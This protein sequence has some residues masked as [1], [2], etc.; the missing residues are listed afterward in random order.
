[1]SY[2]DICS[3]VALPLRPCRA[4]DCF[5]RLWDLR[6]GQ[7][8]RHLHCFGAAPRYPSTSVPR[9]WRPLLPKTTIVYIGPRLSSRSLSSARIAKHDAAPSQA[10]I[11]FVSPA[12]SEKP[13]SAVTRGGASKSAK[14]Q[15]KNPEHWISLLEKFLPGDL[16][17]SFQQESRTIFD[18]RTDF[19]DVLKIVHDAKSSAGVDILAY[20]ALTKHRY[21]AVIHLADT[22][23]KPVQMLAEESTDEQLPSNIVWPRYTLS[24]LVR[25]PVELD[26][27][28][29]VKRP[30]AAILV[31]SSNNQDI[32][33][34][35]E[36]VMPL[37]WP[38]LAE[39]VITSVQRPAAEAKQIMYTVHQ[40]IARIHHV[41]LIPASVY[42]HSVPQA[43]TTIQYPPILSL[44]RS[45]ILSTLSDAVWQAHQD[46]AIARANSEGLSRQDPVASE[47]LPGG[48]FRRKLRELGP[49]VWIEFILW[50]CVEGGYPSAGAR[51][52]GALRKDVD[53][54]WYA[55]HWTSGG[56]GTENSIPPID[57]ER[58]RRQPEG[59]LGGSEAY[60]R[61]KPTLEIPSR[62]ISVE[63]VL[64]LVDCLI[65]SVDSVNLRTTTG[66]ATRISEVLAFLEPHG[67]TP[68]YFDYLAVRLLQTE[69]FRLRT[70]PHAL[71]HWVSIVSRLRSLQ[72]VKA[73]LFRS[74]TLLFEYI[75]EHTGLHAG[76]FHQVL[77]AY[78]EANLATKGV[79]TLTHIQRLVD[80]S[81][82]EAIGEF[83]SG[84]V[85]PLDGFFT[86]RPA[87][88]HT[89]YV[90]SYGQLPEYKLPLVISLVTNAKLF[91]LSD[92]LLHSP[93]V[94]GPLIPTEIRG[95][96]SIAIGLSRH[97]IAKDDLFLLRSVI[98]QSTGSNRKP[99]VNL[100]RALANAQIHF[101]AWD[102]VSFLLR[103]LRISEAGG[104]SP[105]IVA[106]LAA[107]MLRLEAESASQKKDVAIQ[108]FRQAEALLSDMLSGRYDSPKSDFTIIQRKSFKQQVSF[109][110]RLLHAI[111]DSGLKEIA[112]QHL[113]KFP[114]SNSPNLERDAFNTVLS[115]V[116]ETRGSLE[117]RRLWDIFCT[118]PNQSSLT[119]GSTQSAGSHSAEVQVH[120]GAPE[121]SD[122]LSS[123]GLLT[124]DDWSGAQLSTAGSILRDERIEIPFTGFT[125]PY[126]DPR[127]YESPTPS[128]LMTEDDTTAIP[129]E[130]ALPNGLAAGDSPESP[131]VVPDLQTLQ[132][133]VNA[134]LAEKAAKNGL[135]KEQQTQL[136]NILA[137]AASVAK[138]WGLASRDIEA[139]LNIPAAFHGFF[140]SPYPSLSRKRQIFKDKHKALDVSTYF[141][142]GALR[143]KLP[144]IR[145]GSRKEYLLGS[146]KDKD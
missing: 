33:R 104:Y 124:T 10:W 96:P 4:H 74:P 134:A 75:L 32:E 99:T 22:L 117:G 83:L 64:A 141:T 2:W 39:L 118:P 89:E 137:W 131:I 91:G 97:A 55:V 48:R 44:L 6:Y 42:T 142:R 102:D 85:P 73:R 135:S 93:D 94:D 101:R 1:M 76:L 56:Q 38:F 17:L 26:A 80:A 115:A 82:L 16:R 69:N 72:T 23:L 35:H 62:T 45:R 87:K 8:G 88:R 18:E 68:A 25:E 27:E 29:Y 139:E 114:V 77:Q 121:N 53:F 66:V 28:S 41:G 58:I 125:H 95:R 65:N 123:S 90:D 36:R 63:V 52:I 84:G 37:L 51:I 127:D 13:T 11:P 86:S 109:I 107:T 54:P 98:E 40:I 67:L 100:L 138:G 108:D 34:N 110:L 5:T 145:Y 78:V 119:I 9:Y 30:S 133:L 70:N 49:E 120:D 103:R 21:K 143:P 57:W 136:D 129:F 60:I 47:V 92:W 128:S 7:F 81:K 24:Q 140:L 71:D 106:N 31:Q 132:I 146:S 14:N 20:M 59:A 79:D 15:K 126:L 113:P 112:A 3:I 46:E 111:P 61:E 105:S 12:V 19:E 43:P 116:V 50:C 122:D 130:S 144:T